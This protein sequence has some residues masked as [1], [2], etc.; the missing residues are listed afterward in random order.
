MIKSVNVDQSEVETESIEEQPTHNLFPL[1]SRT[2]SVAQAL[3]SDAD[4]RAGY[5]RISVG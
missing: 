3:S 4:R 5:T 1:C 2:A